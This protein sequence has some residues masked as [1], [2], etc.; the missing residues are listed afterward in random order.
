MA[1]AGFL[2]QAA[3]TMLGVSQAWLWQKARVSRKTINDFENGY[4]TPKLALI[5]SIRQALEAAGA[6]FVFG[7]QTVGVVVYES[8]SERAKSMTTS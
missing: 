3:R 4:S 1:I 8:F 7:D 6:Q 5:L 2:A